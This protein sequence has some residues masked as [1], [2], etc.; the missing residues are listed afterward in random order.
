MEFPISR[1][2]RLRRTEALRSLV[3]ETHLEPSALILPLFLCPG[4][5][6][7]REIGSMPGVF[8]V[9]VDEAVK[10]A[11][12]AAALGVG[13]LLLFGLPDTKDE[14]ATGAWDDN[15]IVQKGLRAL[16]QSAA[17]K[18]LVLIA[19]VCLCEYTSHGHCGI[20]QRHGDEF[21]IENDS[22]LALLAKTGVSL[23]RAGADIVAPSDMMDGRV[24]AMR[25][26][27]DSE[28]LEQV[29]ILSYASKFASAFYGPFREAAASAP[30]FGDRRSYQMDGANLREA[31]REI[32]LDLGE[33][34]D[35]V[36]MKPAMPY[37]DV[38]RA[39]RENFDVPIGAYQ[40]SG[41]YSML[42][43]AFARGWLEPQRA[44]MESL[45]SIRRAG[46][47]FIVTYFANEA[48]KVLA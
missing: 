41:E 12:S 14:Q 11:E 31:M 47:G 15:G 29:P 45:V 35:M 7:R 13:G 5:G 10:E 6:I 44:M 40:V 22:T 42:Q 27:L 16:K 19:D 38:I 25:D 33:G 9:S 48:A 2:R 21:E 36:L 39:A 1:M 8:N 26:E 28:D 37:L 46:A 4:E 17:S 18:K 43:A 34:A 32:D 20:V 30:Q 24:A 3:R 23:A